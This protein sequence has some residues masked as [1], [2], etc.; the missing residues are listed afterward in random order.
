MSNVGAQFG[1]F[2]RYHH[3]SRE[4]S[5]AR[6]EALA[7]LMDNA[8]AIPGS[9]IRFGLDAM[10]GLVPVIGDLVSQAIASYIIWEA[11]RLGVSRWTMMRMIANSAV[12][13]AVG[14][15]PVVG[16]LF[17]IHFRANMRNLELLRAHMK[18]TGLSANG[19]I[20]EGTAQRL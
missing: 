9:N 8:V 7:K 10:I 18:R 3:A 16:D 19:P 15:V 2:E 14:I 13:T 1:S 11:R 17:D 5:L 4:A 20:I 6:L 12:D